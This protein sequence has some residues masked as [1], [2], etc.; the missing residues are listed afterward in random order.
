MLSM[1]DNNIV[2]EDSEE[3]SEINDSNKSWRKLF[4]R[5]STVSP[6][7]FTSPS[8]GRTIRTL[9]NATPL[10]KSFSPSAVNQNKVI[11]VLEDVVIKP[12]CSNQNNTDDQDVF[13]TPKRNKIPRLSTC[14]PSG[15]PNEDDTVSLASVSK[16][17]SLND[18]SVS[19][20][21]SLNSSFNEDQFLNL[22]NTPT[23]KHND[24]NKST[25]ISLTVNDESRSD[26]P[27]AQFERSPAIRQISADN[28]C[29]EHSDSNSDTSYVPSSDDISDSSEPS[30]EDEEN[31]I[32]DPSTVASICNDDDEW[33]DISDSQPQFEE[34]TGNSR[35][36]IPSD[37]KSPDEFY[38]L[39]LTDEVID[40]IVLETNNYASKCIQSDQLKN[41][42]RV[43]QW[44]PTNR[45]EM[46]NFFCVLLVMG[47]VKVPNLKY[48]W[49]KKKL[50][51][52]E[53]IASLMSRDR[54]L[55]LLKFWHFSDDSTSTQVDK[56]NK[57]RVVY[58]M[59]LQQFKKILLPGKVLVIDESMVPWRG[60]LR[61]RQFIKKKSYR[62]GVK[63]YK[64]CTPEGYTFNIIIYTGKGDGG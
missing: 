19:N 22:L 3:K 37:I 32:Q 26:F 53:Y 42:S 59:I 62:Y 49:S 38:R 50:Y 35:L 41:K 31:I 13:S 9:Q 47:I 56:L 46:L 45:E 39:F 18:I 15:L 52:N 57:I 51:R 4:I 14:L 40:K 27:I 54:F 5:R 23:S 44:K 7:I 30:S 63:L 17:G 10:P 29:Q 60:R 61:F 48:Y 6:T 1:C 34:Y 36:F 8:T 2:K 16:C 55:L 25:T 21:V 11:R 24:A 64:L 43:R 28:L 58:E 33:Q 20:M 12:G